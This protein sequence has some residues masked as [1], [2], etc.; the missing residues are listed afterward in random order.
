MDKLYLD[1]IENINNLTDKYEIGIKVFGKIKSENFSDLDELKTVR[2]ISEIKNKIDC[3]AYLLDRIKIYEEEKV[4]EQKCKVLETILLKDLIVLSEDYKILKGSKNNM[5][6]NSAFLIKKGNVK[7]FET[8]F[9][10][11]KMYAPEYSFLFS[12][13]WP[14]YNFIKITKKVSINGTNL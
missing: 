2:R 14:P 4:K 3:R 10:S 13:P 6:L 7:A 11:I 12:G 8:G 5:L 9:D 1:L